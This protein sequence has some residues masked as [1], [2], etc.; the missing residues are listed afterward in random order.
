MI[1]PSSSC[2]YL[3]NLVQALL[4]MLTNCS[5]ENC[6]FHHGSFVLEDPHATIFKELITDDCKSYVRYAA[7][8]HDVFKTSKKF[9][10]HRKTSHSSYAYLEH[11]SEPQREIYV[12]D[13]PEWCKNS[14][15]KSVKYNIVLFYPFTVT[16]DTVSKRYLFLKLESHPYWHPKHMAAALNKYVFKREKGTRDEN[17]HRNNPE[18]VNLLEQDIQMYLNN[19]GSKTRHKIRRLTDSVLFYETNVRAYME[20]F[21]PYIVLTSAIKRAI[22]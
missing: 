4:H 16:K 13:L 17:N 10:Q 1:E 5:Q 21:I 7:Q 8:T 3:V 20:L 12:R 15:S 2:K 11:S 6:C 19:I 22:T 9:N 14:I 18:N